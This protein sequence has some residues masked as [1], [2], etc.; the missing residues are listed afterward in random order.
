MRA[1]VSW[2]ASK[3]KYKVNH[4]A[5]NEKKQRLTSLMIAE[6]SFWA[7]TSEALS[8]SALHLHRHSRAMVSKETLGVMSTYFEKPVI[9]ISCGQ[10]IKNMLIIPV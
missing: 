5:R 10:R 9:Y 4:E 2:G 3:R 8:L 7:A 6:S 1:S